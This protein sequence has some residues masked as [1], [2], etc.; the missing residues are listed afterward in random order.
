VT[1]LVFNAIQRPEYQ[2]DLWRTLPAKNHAYVSWAE[3]LLRLADDGTDFDAAAYR[4]RLAV[5][6]AVHAIADTL[7]DWP[8]S[9]AKAEMQ[10]GLARVD[11]EQA[12]DLVGSRR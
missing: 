5:A 8:P 1:G 12:I 7:R 10:A 3:E 11:A 2:R 4:Y 9:P 6:D